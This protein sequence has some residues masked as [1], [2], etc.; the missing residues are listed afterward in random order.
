MRT[1]LVHALPFLV[2]AAS[3][4]LPLFYASPAFGQPA[5]LPSAA[6]ATGNQAPPPPNPSGGATPAPSGGLGSDTSTPIQIPPPPTVDDP[7]LAPVVPARRAIATWEEALGYLRARSTDL[8]IAVDEVRRAEALTRVALGAM[9]TQINGSAVFTHQ[10]IT[11][12]TP[13]IPGFSTGT[14]PLQNLVSGGITAVQPLI[15]IGSTDQ[16]N[17]NRLGER[18]AQLSV[19]DLKRTLALGVANAIVGVITAERIAE[20]NRIGFRSALERLDLTQRKKLLGAANGL[21]VVRSHQDVETARATLV[22]GDESLRQ[23]RESLGLAL[24]IPEQVGVTPDVNIDGLERT[25]LRTCQIAPSVDARADVAAARKKVEIAKRNI[26]NVYYNFLPTLNAQSNVGTSS[27]PA[28]TPPTVWNIQAVL[29]VPI[30][31]GGIKYGNLRQARAL[32]D[33]AE[34][35]LEALRRGAIIQIEQARR[36]VSVA[37]QSRKVAGDAR[38]LA[39]ETDRLTQISY[40]EGQATSLELVIS[41]AALRQAEVSLAL[42][43]F[44]L[45]KARILDVLALATCPW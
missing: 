36:G 12:A 20:L 17:I 28:A 24:G 5:P 15:N 34:Q 33:E 42:Q 22:T 26:D 35:Q 8:R 29:S 21:D 9:L 39:A 23:A 7:M 37:E 6:A 19:E 40:R 16:I 13:V 14:S 30:W 3:S 11:V 45:V 41:A 25:A 27:N 4:P 1:A 43:D 2:L 10:F 44:G 32:E 31:D 18:A 38:A